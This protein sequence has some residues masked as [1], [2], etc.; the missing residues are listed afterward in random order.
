MW[1]REH[2]KELSTRVTQQLQQQREQAVQAEAA[3]AAAAAKAA[4]A[5]ARRMQAGAAAGN[6]FAAVV[7]QAAK[8]QQAAASSTGAGTSGGKGARRGAALPALQ[9]HKLTQHWKHAT[10]ASLVASGEQ[11]ARERK[12]AAARQQVREQWAAV[13]QR[14]PRGAPG[15]P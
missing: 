1:A 7:Q 10:A 13:R 5:A 4:A 8:Q 14:L 9:L 6:A 11:T 12:A 15:Q 3:R 2:T